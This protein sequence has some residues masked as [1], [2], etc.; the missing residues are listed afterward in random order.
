MEPLAPVNAA[1]EAAGALPEGAWLDWLWR[2]DP[3]E[4]LSPAVLLNRSHLLG[5]LVCRQQ[6]RL[7]A[8]A[9]PVGA[10]AGARVRLLD[11][12][13]EAMTLR[14]LR[15]TVDNLLLEWAPFLRR[16]A[17]NPQGPASLAAVVRLVDG[18]FARLGRLA[19]TPGPPAVF[20][21]SGGTEPHDA[22]EGGLLR[23]TRPCLRRLL[24][25]FLVLYRH[26]HLLTVAEEV[27]PEPYDCGV[28]RHHLEASQDEYHA[29]CMS[30]ALPVAARITYKLDFPGMYN[31][32]S[33]VQTRIRQKKDAD[34]WRAGA[35]TRDLGPSCLAAL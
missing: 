2:T 1:L 9:G 8:P 7:A 18:C 21:D 6:A 16:T 15:D 31:H 25:A 23:L 29:L 35:R 26:L 22:V 5:L 34:P 13:P 30:M 14:E 27:P 17:Q 32:V 20:N 33:Q 12:P 19:E 28:C 4:P 3:E 11:T 24:N 10:E